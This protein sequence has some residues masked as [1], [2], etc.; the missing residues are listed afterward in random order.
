MA[1][2]TFWEKIA[3]RFCALEPQKRVVGPAEL[4][5][6]LQAHWISTSW[7][8]AGD[9]WYIS[10]GADKAVHKK[11]EWLAE[12]A[13]AELG[14][15]G[16]A[17]AVAYW[18]ELLRRDSP[19]YQ[20]QGAGKTTKSDGSVEECRIGIIQRLC[21]AAADYCLR[22][23]TDRILSS[24]NPDRPELR[25]GAQLQSRAIP[26]PA[27]QHSDAV[28]AARARTVSHIIAELDRLRPSMY[29]SR[30]YEDL[31][32]QHP[33]FLTFEIAADHSE[34]RTKIVNLQAHRRHIRLAQELAAAYY[35]RAFETIRTDWKKAKPPDE[36][37]KR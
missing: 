28:Q 20:E 24:R 26:S 18:L 32:Q 3:T 36:R 19:S 1:D 2:T 33:D 15:A 12:R 21:E 27:T 23:E 30:D 34:L 31:K 5:D 9:Q 35:G 29:S 10:G 7:N 37:R 16:G 14:H 8:E 11:F 17:S 6:P 13:A 25:L 22:C 4:D